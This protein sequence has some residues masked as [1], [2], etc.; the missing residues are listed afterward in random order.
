MHWF[1]V[2]HLN[3]KGNDMII[4]PL[5]P[6]FARKTAVERDEAIRD[7][8]SAAKEAGLKGTVVAIWPD[9]E[10]LHFVAP[11]PWRGFFKGI[12]WPWIE[13]NLNKE[14]LVA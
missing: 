7:M 1:Q 14:L 2:A 4:V 11:S 9:G 13:R 10:Q 5:S 6:R 8:Q 3:I 12:T